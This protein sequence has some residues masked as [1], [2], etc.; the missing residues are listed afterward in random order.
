[1]GI[2]AAGTLMLSVSLGVAWSGALPAKDCPPP[3]KADESA[4]RQAS[5][6]YIE[7]WYAGDVVRMT[8]ALHPE[9]AKRRVF[10]DPKSGRSVLEQ[11]GAMTLV[12][13][14]QK[15]YG[16]ETPKEQQKKDVAVLDICRDAASVRIDAAGWIDYMHLAKWN[17]EW[18]IV[19]V[20]WESE[21]EAR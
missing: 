8:R 3:T 1:M 15:A 7:G 2:R 19:N 16:A 9:L 6:D 13:K 4:V 11:M 12:Q 14:T 21:P 20:L 17:G 18:K 5:L 10:T